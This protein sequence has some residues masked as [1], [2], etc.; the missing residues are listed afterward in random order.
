MIDAELHGK[1]PELENSEDLLTSSVFGMLKYFQGSTVLFK[2]LNQAK[3]L[4]GQMPF[5]NCK[6]SDFTNFEIEFWPNLQE[7]G[8]P[9]MLIR[10]EN[11]QGEEKVL[12]VEVK[13][14]SGKSSFGEHDQLKKYYNY[15]NRINPKNFLGLIYLTKHPSETEFQESLTEIQKCSVDNAEPKLFS[16]NWTQ[17]LDMISKERINQSP[18]LDHILS[19]I[20]KYMEKKNLGSFKG[21]SFQSEGFNIK[22]PEVVLYG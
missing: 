15:L 18:L 17:V 2:I 11:P 12:C 22:T 1:I 6:E 5:N 8:E 19:D 4:S 9:D 13:L 3:G 20:E 16:L 14:D 10:F 21:F 7:A